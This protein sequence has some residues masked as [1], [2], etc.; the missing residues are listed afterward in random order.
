MFIDFLSMEV[1]RGLTISLYVLYAIIINKEKTMSPKK[2][3]KQFP[4]TFTFIC[5]S[6]LFQNFLHGSVVLLFTFSLKC[7]FETIALAIF[8][9]E[10]CCHVPIWG[11]NSFIFFYS[12]VSPCAS[13]PSFLF[14]SFFPRFLCIS[15]LEIDWNFY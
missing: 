14:F 13:F 11:Y 6:F 9:W 1:H 7:D 10:T 5:R 2:L 3:Q 8:M 4:L 15:F 12:L